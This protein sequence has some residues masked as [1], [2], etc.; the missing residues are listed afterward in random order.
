MLSLET[1]VMLRYLDLLLERLG[2]L[3]NSVLVGIMIQSSFGSVI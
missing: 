1:M 2:L 3:E